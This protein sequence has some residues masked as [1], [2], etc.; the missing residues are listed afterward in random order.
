MNRSKWLIL[1][2]AGI[3]CL[4]IISGRFFPHELTYQ[5]IMEGRTPMFECVVTDDTS[6]NEA[7][8]YSILVQPVE[9]CEFGNKKDLSSLQK[10]IRIFEKDIQY[11]K[12][13][14]IRSYLK[15]GNL[16][17]YVF[18]VHYKDD[19]SFEET[20]NEMILRNVY[21]LT[22]SGRKTDFDKEQ[23]ANCQKGCKAN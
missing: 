16:E 8:D 20:E 10:P 6:F 5:E 11:D 12:L 22:D 1:I 13:D 2:I 19:A 14:V 17:E 9:T 15:Q 21:A 4:F 3:V 23:C 7:G 18:T